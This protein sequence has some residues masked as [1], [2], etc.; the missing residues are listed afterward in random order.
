MGV[1]K[2]IGAK[3]T[4]EAI[5]HHLV[6]ITVDPENDQPKDLLAYSQA[7]GVAKGSWTLLTGEPA[8]VERTVTKQFVTFMGKPEKQPSGLM[9]IGHGGHLLLIDSR[10]RLR[11]TYPATAPETPDELLAHIR[12]LTH[13]D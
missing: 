13:E 3:L 9:D 4:D 10:G 6:S 7:L 8:L 5:P 1:V 11:G 12:T 2:G